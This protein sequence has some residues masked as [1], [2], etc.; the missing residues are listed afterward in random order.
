M[1]GQV[2]LG[3]I[4]Q[5]HEPAEQDVPPPCADPPCRFRIEALRMIRQ[6]GAHALPVEEQI[7]AVS[8][9]FKDGQKVIEV[10]D[11]SPHGNLHGLPE[12]HAIHHHRPRGPGPALGR[13]QCQQRVEDAVP[14]CLGVTRPWVNQW[15]PR[16][17]H[18]VAHRNPPRLKFRGIGEDDQCHAQQ[19]CLPRGQGMARFIAQAV[20]LLQPLAAAF[21]GDIRSGEGR[22]VF[23]P[24]RHEIVGLGGIPH[25]AVRDLLADFPAAG[26][27]A[28]VC[29]LD[30]FRAH[31]IIQ[32][33]R[34]VHVILSQSV[35]EFSR[36]CIRR[37]ASARAHFLRVVRDFLCEHGFQFL[38]R[39]HST[40]HTQ[41]TQQQRAACKRQNGPAHEAHR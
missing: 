16:C 34:R 35:A 31:L 3:S 25:H 11:Q 40:K 10:A 6:A 17:D 38:D 41:S 15:L 5:S 8:T 1:L 39:Q 36:Q 19:G 7:I 33:L 13:I 37:D 30:P 22:E 27:D 4:A 9:V 29:R 26:G 23:L 2:I 21:Q 28:W 18:R 12:S 14:E 32:P 24:E 20:Q